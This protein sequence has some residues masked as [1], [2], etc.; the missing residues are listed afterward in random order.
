MEKVLFLIDAPEFGGLE[1]VLLDWLSGI[2]YSKA[3]VV[4][5]QRGDVLKEKLVVKGLP[6][7]SIKLTIPDGE[8]FWKAFLNW[9]R[10]LSSIRPQKI[11][12]VEAIVGEF[13]L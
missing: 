9:L 4:L 5:C 8:S 2:E 3:S 7:E 13:N 10:L 12:F 11:V 6:V 1:T